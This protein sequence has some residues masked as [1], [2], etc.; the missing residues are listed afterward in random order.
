MSCGTRPAAGRTRTPRSR[1]DSE[2]GVACESSDRHLHHLSVIPAKAGFR[3]RQRSWIA[4]SAGMTNKDRREIFGVAHS[5]FL[6]EHALMGPYQPLEPRLLPSPASLPQPPRALLHHQR[7]YLRH[8]R[9]RR[10][11]LWGE[12]ED[13]S[14]DDVALVDEAEAVLVHLLRLGREAGDEVGADRQ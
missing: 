6:D 2:Q 10:P 14:H 8:S 5:V 13:M 11:F 7:R 9:R 1:G 12:G 4:A 3:T